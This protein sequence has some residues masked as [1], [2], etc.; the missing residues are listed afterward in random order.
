MTN[1]ESLRP[2]AQDLADHLHSLLF[3]LCARQRGGIAPGDE[4]TIILY[5]EVHWLLRELS[6]T[7]MTLFHTPRL[8]V[9]WFGGQVALHPALI[10]TA[11]NFV[12][13][14]HMRLFA[15]AFLAG[16]GHTGG[17]H[18]HSP[19]ALIRILHA[20]QARVDSNV[21]GVTL[22]GLASMAAQCALDAF[23]FLAEPPSMEE[24]TEAALP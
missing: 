12:C 18:A 9:C 13:S 2:I 19:L 10:E 4:L 21:P 20:I 1:M 5:I 22:F 23:L 3:E 16:S 15:L 7:L 24:L 8:V 11:G 17:A 6:Q 14:A